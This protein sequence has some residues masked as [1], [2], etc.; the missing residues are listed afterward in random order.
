MGAEI[1]QL[2]NCNC[3]SCLTEK[4][5]LKA[6]ISK[7][8]EVLKEVEG[9]E[10]GK[11][12]HSLFSHTNKHLQK[13]VESVF[14]AKYE[15]DNY[16]LVNNLKKNSAYFSAFK[17]AY[18]TNLLKERDKKEHDSII[19]N[20]ERHLTTEGNLATRS[21]RSAK[22]WQ[23][24]ERTRD[25]YPNLEYLSSRSADKREEH[26]ELYGVIKPINDDFW[27][28][29]YPPNGWGCKCRTGKSDDEVTEPSPTVN[30]PNGLAGNVALDKAIFTNS[31]PFIKGVGVNGKKVIKKEF[32][33]L[34]A[35]IEY[36]TEADYEAK[37]NSSIYVHSFADKNDLSQNFEVAKTLVN[38]VPDLEI[39][40]R[41]HIN[42]D[43][44]I[45]K[46][47]QSN[48]EYLINGAYGDLKEVTTKNINNRFKSAKN[49]GCKVVVFKIEQLSIDRAVKLIDGQIKTREEN[50]FKRIFILKDNE[51][52][53]HK[54]RADTSLSSK[55]G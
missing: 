37:N 28:T 23:E 1:D 47:K 16:D 26:K 51:V 12:S 50:P 42:G 43:T 14:S 21:A 25:I 27:K 18:Y 41:P 33:Q 2:Y 13:S 52:F 10:D 48:P 40:I 32:E 53:E 38:Q 9:L 5:I 20:Y 46:N 49:Q 29:H 54:K 36:N 45:G 24:Y 3:V 15:D 17:S 31:H 55:G 35:K 39:K 11:L 7:P 8:K 4:I 6:N 19:A 22:Q 34:K 44:G 30:I